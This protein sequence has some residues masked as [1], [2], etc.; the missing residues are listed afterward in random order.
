MTDAARDGD[1]VG[2]RD[3]D[4]FTVLV[5]DGGTEAQLRA[6]DLPSPWTP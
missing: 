2:E 3:G 4:G 5:V 6:T 1:A